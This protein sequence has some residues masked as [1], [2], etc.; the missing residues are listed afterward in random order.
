MWR[1]LWW[2]FVGAM[3]LGCSSGK[4]VDPVTDVDAAP[5]VQPTVPPPPPE[6]QKDDDCAPHNCCFAISPEQ[7]G[8]LAGAHCDQSRIECAPYAGPRYH[9]TC[10][11]GACN[12]S[13]GGRVSKHAPVAPATANPE[14]ETAG[15]WVTGALDPGLVLPVIVSHAGDVRACQ[16]KG[17]GRA[18]G[19]VEL[20]ISV[21]PNGTVEAVTPTRSGASDPSLEKCVVERV[22]A[23]RF[24]AKKGPSK[25]TYA[26]R[27]Q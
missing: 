18:Y 19:I 27:F 15:Q 7:C 21:R 17:R 11:D 16:A 6:C 3:L 4:R 23:W 14:E 26:F 12:A 13:N 5:W 10:V 8:T 20:L 1:V 2:A 25:V 22:K 24:P 9:C